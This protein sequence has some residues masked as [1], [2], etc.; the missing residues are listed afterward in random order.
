MK[1][2]FVR[3]AVVASLFL[4]WLAYLAYL[5]FGTRDSL[6]ISRPQFLVSDIDVIARIEDPSQPIVIEEVLF[7]SVGPATQLVGKPARILNLTSCAPPRHLRKKE[8]EKDFTGP[9]LYVVPLRRLPAAGDENIFEVAPT[10]P[11]PGYP[12]AGP[13]L[14][15]P[16]RIYP[17]TPEVRSQ[18]RTLAKP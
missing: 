1:G 15:G 18:L 14:P 7:P 2:A 17:A 16:P 10:P 3:L 8:D 13:P 9:G 5:A 6:I 12:V 11:S 4:V